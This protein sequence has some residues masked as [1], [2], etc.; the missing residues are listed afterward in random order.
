MIADARTFW[1][2]FLH[3]LGAMTLFGA[4]LTAFLLAA[5]SWRAPA[6][7]VY[8]SASWRALLAAVPAWVATLACGSWIASDEGF[9]TSTATWLSIGR[10][11]L[12]PGVLVLVAAIGAS[13]WWK[14]GG[15]VL[16]ARAVAGICAAYLVLLA[17]GWLAMSGKW[18]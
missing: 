7:A 10:G 11:V 16:A 14:Q 9:D 2:L 17:V 1:P 3:V 5:V 4:V 13:W 6:P 18:S 8:R 12:E 15:A